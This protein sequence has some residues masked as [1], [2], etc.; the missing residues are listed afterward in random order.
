LVNYTTVAADA[1]KDNSFKL[2]GPGCKTYHLQAESLIEQQDWMLKLGRLLQFAKRSFFQVVGE[3]SEE[4]EGSA[5]MDYK[6]APR[7]DDCRSIVSSS[8]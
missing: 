1:S 8:R 5:G 2:S 7:L 6:A 4:E 3:G